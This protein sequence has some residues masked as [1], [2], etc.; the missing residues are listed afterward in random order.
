[1][2]KNKLKLKDNILRQSKVDRYRLSVYKSNTNIFAQI[3]DDL[4]N[5]TL[6]SYSSINIKKG[7]KSEQ[8]AKVGQE[9]AGLALKNKINKVYLDRKKLRYTGRLKNLCESAR[10][11]GLLF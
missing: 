8:S 3:I 11:Q 7:T 2:S 4:Q 9:L 6:V 10:K 5:I 1:M